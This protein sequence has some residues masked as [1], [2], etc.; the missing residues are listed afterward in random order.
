MKLKNNFPK[1]VRNLYL[2]E[3]GCWVCSRSDQGLELHHIFGRVSSSPCNASVVCM[4]CHS[5][6]GHSRKEHVS[7]LA[8]SLK[9]L[10]KSGY[11]HDMLDIAF[12]NSVKREFDNAVKKIL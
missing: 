7:L 3:Y 10:A 1:H 4:E 9:F 5:H 8:K 12:L 11:R 6:M 2:Y